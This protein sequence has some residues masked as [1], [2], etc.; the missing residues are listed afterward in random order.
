MRIFSERVKIQRTS[1]FASVLIVALASAGCV[2]A[3]SPNGASSSAEADAGP[4]QYG[5]V[6]RYASVGTQTK[7]DPIKRTVMDPSMNA[8]YDTLMRYDDKGIPEP[9]LAEALSSVDAKT[10]TLKLRPDVKF[11]DGAK[12]DADAVVFNIKRHQDPAN[13]SA[14]A[15]YVR[16][17]ESAVASDPLT[18]LFTLKMPIASFPSTLTTAVGAIASPTA[19]AAAGADYG[20]KSAV[21][22]GAFRFAEWQPD[23]RLTLKRNPEYW[24][25]G[26][27]YLDEFQ[28]LPMSDTETR[29][30]AF[31]GGQLE[32]AWLGEPLEINWA[33]GNPDIARL[34]SP[35]GGVGGVGVGFQMNRPPFDDQRL[36][37]AVAMAIDYNA[38]NQT[39]FQGKMP[40]MR[41]PFIEGSFWYTGTAKWPEFNADGARALVNEYKAE[42]GG[43]LAFT[44]SCHSAAQARRLAETLQSLFTQ[45]GMTVTLDTPD[46]GKFVNQ[47][48][49]GDYQI[50]CWTR[51]GSEPDVAYYPAFTCNGPKTQNVFSYCS[52]AADKALS[53]A[54]STLNLDERKA[55]YA[56]FEAEIAKDLPMLWNWG[57]V[58]SVITRPKA[59]GFKAD[60]GNPVDYQPAYLW[61]EK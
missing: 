42:H 34:H 12:L 28:E 20:R 38:L 23:Q 4:P 33:A 21:G 26:L 16:D 9:Y 7:Y 24:Q 61:L 25:K 57:V 37:K 56:R 6:F 30:A 35:K 49:A 31:T 27:P 43:Q 11:H 52:E 54:R 14:A 48:F 8:I 46:V 17:I 3:T 59:H 2:S 45:V 55:G 47:V 53:D 60:L 58:F 44:L 36:R 15:S 39:Q 19:V 29:R 10:W 1:L 13:A 40:A 22:A 18:V 51:S 50:A 41:G 5:G 32:A